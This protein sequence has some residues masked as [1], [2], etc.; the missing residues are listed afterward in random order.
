MS[1]GT[2]PVLMRNPG[3]LRERYRY[4]EITPEMKRKVFG[5]NSA[6]LY[7]M[8]PDLT[9]YAEVPA[10]YYPRPPTGAARSAI[11]RSE[12]GANVLHFI[13]RWKLRRSRG[14]PS[15]TTRPA[16]TSSTRR[17]RPM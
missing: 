5:L 15:R 6:R 16:A 11:P 17:D 12:A 2:L 4:P 14:R 7:G 3:A 10:D 8:A 9:R 13:Q 1:N